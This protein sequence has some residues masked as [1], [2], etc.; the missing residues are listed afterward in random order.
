MGWLREWLAEVI[1]LTIIIVI[2]LLQ[3]IGDPF[4]IPESGMVL[5]DQLVEDHLV[6]EEFT[7]IKKII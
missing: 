1:H 5:M 4:R 3:L 2:N 7:V 6:V